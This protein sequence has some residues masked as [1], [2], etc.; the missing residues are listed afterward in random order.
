MAT[1]TEIIVWHDVNEQK[2]DEE[3]TVMLS[4]RDQNEPVW[5]GYLHDGFW[6]EI[7]GGLLPQKSVTHWAL[8]PLG[9]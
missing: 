1:K 3:T 8:M 5:L 6:F 7:Q 2:P 4:H 9:V